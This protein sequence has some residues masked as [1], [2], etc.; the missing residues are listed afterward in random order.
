[1]GSVL[2][3]VF[4][5]LVLLRLGLLAVAAVFLIGPVSACPACFRP[6]V[7]LLIR[8]L[9]RLAPWLEWR[10]CPDCAWQGPARRT[11]AQSLSTT[12][13]ASKPGR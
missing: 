2:V 10:W 3:A 9:R 7:P 5:G 6:T 8:P 12:I 13:S 1:M 4:A 11:G